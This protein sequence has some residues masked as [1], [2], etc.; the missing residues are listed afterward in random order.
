M[1]L[2]NTKNKSRK[3]K[4]L[5]NLRINELINIPQSSGYCYIRWNLKEGTGTSSSVV[6][7]NGEVKSVM[8]QS[9]GHTPKVKVENHRARW[10]YEFDRP[11]QVKLLVDKNR[12]L[13]PKNMILEV[14]FEF[15]QENRETLPSGTRSRSHSHGHTPEPVSN[16]VYAQRTTGKLLLG[17]VSLNIAEYVKED[18]QAVTN[19]FLLKKSKVNSILNVTMQLSLARGTYNDFNVPRNFTSGQLPGT[20]RSGIGDILEDTSDVGSL[21]S[22]AYQSSIG[23]PQGTRHIISE[24]GHANGSG[25]VGNG[26]AHSNLGSSMTSPTLPTTTISASMSPLVDNLYQKTF[27][28][29]WDPRPGEFTPRECVEDIL[30]GG[31]G[32]AKNEKGICLIDLQALRL[33]ELEND[34]Y[35]GNN[36]GGGDETENKASEKTDEELPTS[37]KNYDSIGKKEF[38]EKRQN[39]SLL[40]QSQ[41]EK[42]RNAHK[43]ADGRIS[44]SREE[45]AEEIS[46]DKVRDARSW[47]VN[48]IM[49]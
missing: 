28:L 7:A 25:G 11:L 16:N 5:L 19:R 34:Y 12:D 9:H 45:S 14:Y 23:S 39:W 20:F 26:K 15:L 43:V 21:Q 37:S 27:Q 33:N 18:E 32:W 44:A 47:S 22:S 46:V 10:N 49:A 30:Q 38:L 13:V 8:T 31:N 1:P 24:N 41:R 17:V 40:S 2:L 36:F 42:L 4:F 48:N 3:P 29:P 6:G 35:N